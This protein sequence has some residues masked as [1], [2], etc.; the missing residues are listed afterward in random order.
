MKK[1]ISLILCVTLF[2]LCLNGFAEEAPEAAITSNLEPKE[3]H[4]K[5][6]SDERLLSYIEDEVYDQLITDLDSDQYIIEDVT[7][8]YISREYIE[9]VA[10]NSKENI[11]YGYTLAE[12]D[13]FF[14][15]TR[16][17]FTVNEDGETVVEPLQVIEDKTFERILR[18]VAIG[19]GVILVFV[20][21]SVLTAGAAPAVSMIFAVGAKTAVT[22]AASGTLISGVT[23][24]A[25]KYY[26]TGDLNEALK[27]GAVGASEGYKWGAITGAVS[28]AASETSFLYKWHKATSIPWNEAAIIQRESR[29][30]IDFIRTVHSLDEYNVY[31]EAGLV[32]YNIGGNRVLVPK[33]FDFDMK[34]PGTNLTNRQ[35]MERG[36]NPVDASGLK[37]NWHHV[38]QKTDSPLALL[39]YTQHK[40][41]HKILHANLTQSEVHVGDDSIWGAAREALNKAVA[42]YF[43]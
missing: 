34:V 8:V 6:M 21:V 2:T 33:G 14:E 18:N 29:Y 3:I 41:N 42:G 28:G 15:G 24:A 37:Y 9:E 16:Y 27:A 30:S 13:E 20:T 7:A 17:V 31:K 12:L 35:L 5:G 23:S 10:Y 32:E 22:C 36:L 40:T 1:L 25:V 4:F 39:T 26:E 19:T 43:K 11:F 38:G